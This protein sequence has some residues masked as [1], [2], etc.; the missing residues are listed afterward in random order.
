MELDALACRQAQ[1]AVAEV[2]GDPVQGQP[3]VGMDVAR[4]ESHAD[5]EPE[6]V[7]LASLAAVVPQVAVVLLIRA[8]ELED[9]VAPR[10]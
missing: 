3:Q 8:V 5:H 1:G 9:L 2:A 10:R 4:G 6:G 7:F